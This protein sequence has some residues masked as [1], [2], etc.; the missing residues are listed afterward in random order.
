MGGGQHVDRL[1]GDT[2]R[3]QEEGDA[4]DLQRALLILGCVRVLQ[5]PDD[6][7]RGKDFDQG[8]EPETDERERDRL[9]GDRGSEQD[10]RPNNVPGRASR[11][12][13]IGRGGEAAAR[14]LA[15]CPGC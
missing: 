1:G 15:I 2:G 11:T 12:P 3:G 5:L 8:V 10:H 6:D 7:E 14:S 4:D 13:A 9:G